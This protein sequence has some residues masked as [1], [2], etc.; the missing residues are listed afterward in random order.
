VRFGE[1]IELDAADA[2]GTA[3]RCAGGI[4]KTDREDAGA[5]HLEGDGASTL[6]RAYPDE[7]EHTGTRGSDRPRE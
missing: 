5:P 3:S 7:A 1:S 6:H 4:A 2:R